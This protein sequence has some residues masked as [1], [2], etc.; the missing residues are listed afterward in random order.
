MFG[1]FGVALQGLESGESLDHLLLVKDRWYFNDLFLD[2][3]LR[4]RMASCPAS[5][6]HM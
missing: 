5:W 2:L 1:H 4:K 6:L 3:H